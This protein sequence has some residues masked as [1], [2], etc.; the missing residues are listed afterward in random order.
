MHF[1]LHFAVAEVGTQRFFASLRITGYEKRGCVV[2][3][4]EHLSHKRE[5]LMHT[6]FTNTSKE[7]YVFCDFTYEMNKKLLAFA[8]AM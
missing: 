5:R 7:C 6:Q 4:V 1:I 8:M 2:R 3:C